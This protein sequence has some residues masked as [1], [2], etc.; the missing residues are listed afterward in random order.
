MKK[1]N[2][3]YAEFCIIL[4]LD[5]MWNILDYIILIPLHHFNHFLPCTSTNHHS[6]EI[7]LQIWIPSLILIFQTKFQTTKFPSLKPI[8]RGLISF[9]HQA[10]ES[11]RIPCKISPQP[12]KFTKAQFLLLLKV[13]K[14]SHWILFNFELN[15]H[16][17]LFS[18][19]ILVDQGFGVWIL[20]L[21][22]RI[23]RFGVVIL[24]TPLLS[25][26]FISYNVIL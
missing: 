23:F 11:Q 19:S 12:T 1:I 8:N 5:L 25:S 2:F 3:N 26:I 14:N 10:F 20:K 24:I 22:W 7:S 9:I 16:P 13:N 21:I 18:S 17:H 15:L 4:A 6:F